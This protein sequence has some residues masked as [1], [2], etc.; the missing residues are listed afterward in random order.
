LQSV[1]LQFNCSVLPQFPDFHFEEGEILLFDKP[2][3]WTS[4]DVVNKVRGTIRTKKVGHAGTLDPLATGLLVLCTGKMT[5]KIDTIQATEKEYLVTIGLGKTTPSFDLETE[6]DA[7]KDVS[8]LTKEQVE[9]AVRHF[10]GDQMQLPPMFSAVKVGGKRLYKLARKGQ[11]IELQPRPVTI[12]SIEILNTELPTVQF[13]MRCSK[14]TYVRSLARDIGEKL[15]VG[16]YLAALRR[17]KVGDLSVEDAYD[18]AS[19]VEHIKSLR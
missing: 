5:K 2:L 15:G 10:V 9:A 3:T 18:V 8:H 13:L 12:Y 4:F 11:E 6:F 14:G 7:E 1:V 19:F 16:G 17:T